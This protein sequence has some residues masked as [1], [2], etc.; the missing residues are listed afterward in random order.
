M[1]SVRKIAIWIV[2]G[3]LWGAGSEAVTPNPS[4]DSYQAIVDRNV[5]NLHPPLAREDLT[6]QP[7]VQIPTLTLNGITTI[8]GNKL[9]FLTTPPTKPGAHPETLMLAEG[10]AQDEIEVK[11]IDEKSGMVKV[12]NH[13]EDQTLDFQHNGEKPAAAPPTPLTI[14][15]NGIPPP[16][17]GVDKIRPLRTLPSRTTTPFAGGGNGGG[18]GGVSSGNGSAQGQTPLTPEQQALIIEAQRMKLMQEG[19]PAARILPPTAMT[20]EITGQG[21][22][23]Q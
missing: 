7:K 10:Q 22:A 12:V 2:A 4:S 3:V 5:F 13:G 1:C 15:S 20:P 11:Q 21:Q 19:N 14:P 6:A 18:L 17:R 23:A 8:L 9:A 16:Q